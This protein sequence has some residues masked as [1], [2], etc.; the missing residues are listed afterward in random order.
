[1]QITRQADY[2]IRCILYLAE[3][4]GRI[5]MSK[6]ISRAKKIPMDFLSK[7]LQR[8]TK[9]GLV[10]S[11]RGVKGGFELAKVPEEIDL[12]QVINVIDGPITFNRCA[13]S[14]KLCSFSKSCS[15][16]PI[17]VELRREI[18]G[19]LSRINFRMLISQE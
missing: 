10:R 8:L 1:M 14:K 16:H 17:W 7:I 6:E 4:K 12:L 15:V 2:A 11:H 13:V 19:R 5:T 3:K 9:A 18:E